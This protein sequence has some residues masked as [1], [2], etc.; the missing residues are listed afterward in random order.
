MP[1]RPAQRDSGVV[2]GATDQRLTAVLRPEKDDPEL[3]GSARR[4]H[5]AEV[6]AQLV[7]AERRMLLVLVEQD[8]RSNEASLVGL[9]EAT[10]R[11]EELGGEV[12][13]PERTSYREFRRTFR[14]RRRGNRPASRSSGLIR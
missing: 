8:Q 2:A 4:P 14:V 9:R 13:V 5:A 6:A 12:E 11:L 1:H 3:V 10:E 7:D